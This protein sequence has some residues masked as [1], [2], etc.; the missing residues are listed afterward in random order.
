MESPSRRGEAL[1]I[2][3]EPGAPAPARDIRFLLTLVLRFVAEYATTGQ[4]VPSGSSV[5]V[6]PLA[7][8]DLASDLL[9][10]S[11]GLWAARAVLLVRHHQR[12]QAELAA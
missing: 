11:L 3:G 1:L 8:A 2:L 4:I 7:A 9:L 12:N 10:V 6:H 5:S